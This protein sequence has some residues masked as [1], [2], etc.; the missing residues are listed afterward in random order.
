MP[1]LEPQDPPVSAAAEGGQGGS[2]T[3][4]PTQ[5]GSIEIST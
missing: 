2:T 1:K 3:D 5:K 4:A